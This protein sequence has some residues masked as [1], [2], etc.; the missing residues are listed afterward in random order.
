[1]TRESTR[2][3]GHCPNTVSF[4]RYRLVS[5]TSTRPSLL[6]G[7][8][9]VGALTL[10][11]RVLGFVRELLTAKL[12]GTGLVAD[13]F[14]VAFRIPNLLRSF[15][16]EGALTSA[17]VPVFARALKEGDEETKRTL[18]AVAGFLITLTVVLCTLGIVFAEPMTLAMAPGF[19]S[20]PDQQ[21]L[22]VF[23][24]RL[25]LPFVICISLVALVNSALNA[26]HAYGAAAWGQVW[27][28]VVLIAG[29]VIALPMAPQEVTIF[30]AV[31][32]LL[33]GIVQLI[34]QIPALRRA[35]L[36]IVPSARFA[37]R[38]VRDLIV[39]MVPA[40]LGASV[41]QLYIFS[42][43]LLASILEPG[44]VSWLSFADRI[45]QL[46]MGIYSIALS[47][48]LLPMLASAHE[49]RDHEF[50]NRNLVN[51]LRF[52]SF[53][54]VPFSALI[55][56]A[57]HPITEL[58]FERGAFSRE[59]TA[60]TSLALQALA[61]GLWSASC[62]SLVT[63][64][65]VAQRD[66]W[67][68]TIIGTASLVVYL[69][70]ALAMMG[71]PQSGLAV[72]SVGLIGRAREL[73]PFQTDLGHVGLAAASSFAS[74]FSLTAALTILQHRN[75]DLD[76]R[77]VLRATL[78]AVIIA[79]GIYG[80]TRWIDRSG[81]STISRAALAFT[82]ASAVIVVTSIATRSKEFHE[83]FGKMQT[84][85]AKRFKR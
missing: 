69:V 42:G 17:F 45:A 22:C 51:A 33:G 73:L 3:Q 5:Q 76:L 80:T 74:L 13:A 77:P 53:F 48:V 70:A 40:L 35:H 27:M 44:A 82:V 41:Y 18:A 37:I 29:A 39:L 6:R 31:S 14:F 66:T 58:L 84:I 55:F 54:I 65:F 36:L 16:A 26:K 47:S 49:A 24:T 75:P 71:P 34:V 56:S 52:T 30:L 12:L 20:R 72:G 1:M 85:A 43:T 4:L 2:P 61:I 81:L 60:Q 23:L 64:A 8:S 63:R 50:F 25:M 10:V 15:V 32:V 57:A 7:T 46:P 21:E 59:S 78:T 11:S 62:H 38:P 68:P 28:N 83:I 79:V 67:T 9:I 19:A